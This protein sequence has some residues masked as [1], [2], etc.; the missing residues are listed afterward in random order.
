MRDAESSKIAT[1]AV[2]DD[3]ENRR[4]RICAPPNND[5]IATA[6]SDAPKIQITR[7]DDSGPLGTPISNNT[8]RA[9]VVTDTVAVKGV[10]PLSVTMDGDTVHAGPAGATLHVSETLPLKPP[11][12]ANETG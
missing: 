6:A 9:V 4:A 10:L 1:H 7:C 8:D 2:A 3:H 11:L 12:P 5:R